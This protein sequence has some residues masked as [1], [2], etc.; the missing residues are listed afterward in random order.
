MYQQQS[1][2][3]H[4][5]TIVCTPWASC[6]TWDIPLCKTIC[7]LDHCWLI[8]LWAAALGGSCYDCGETQ[9]FPFCSLF[10]ADTSGTNGSV[11]GLS[12]A[13]Q[14]QYIGLTWCMLY[15]VGCDKA[16]VLNIYCAFLYCDFHQRVH[17]LESCS[18]N[19][20]HT[21]SRC[22]CYTLV[23]RRTKVIWRKIWFKSAHMLHT[24]CNTRH[25]RMTYAVQHLGGALNLTCFVVRHHMSQES[26][27]G[28]R[29]RRN[30]CP[31]VTV[32]QHLLRQCSLQPVE[33]Q[34]LTRLTRLIRKYKS[35]FM[36]KAFGLHLG[37]QTS[38]S[39]DQYLGCIQPARR[40]A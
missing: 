7:T 9:T 17:L 39:G 36:Q 27:R 13:C 19:F 12:S 10:F 14:L 24:Q 34:G 37:C 5:G 18:A 2:F 3:Y 25:W 32:T 40:D 11:I 38:T 1:C 15:L 33:M 6:R 8:S 23:D 4:Q 21:A 28:P 31:S 30:C 22:V 29:R 16:E 26:C 35:L 20:S